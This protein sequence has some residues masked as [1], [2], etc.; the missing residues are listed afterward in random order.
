MK[1]I[2]DNKQ[3]LNELHHWLCDF[4]HCFYDK[5]RDPA[6]DIHLQ[7]VGMEHWS[8]TINLKGTVLEEKEFQQASLTK[9]PVDWISCYRENRNDAVCF[10][11]IGTRQNLEMI[12]ATFKS[13]VIREFPQFAPLEE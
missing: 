6:Q 2:Y 11:G 8:C 3:T 9:T 4:H 13:W 10:R 1:L 5:E 7:L 12:L